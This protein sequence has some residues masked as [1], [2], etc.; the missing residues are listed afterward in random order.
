MSYSTATLLHSGFVTNCSSALRNGLL[1]GFIGALCA[2]S[3]LSD[4]ADA[5]ASQ[6][7]WK[8]VIVTGD[9]FR[10]V[11]YQSRQASIPR[12]T[13]H[14]YIEGD[15][16]PWEAGGFIASAD[17]TPARPLALELMAKDPSPSL[18][19]GRPCYF[20]LATDTACETKYWTSARYST[21]VIASM[22]TAL[23]HYARAQDAERLVLI[24]YSGGGVVATLMTQHLEFPV[25]VV[26]L[27][28]NLDIDTWAHN[29]RFLPLDQSINPMNSA[30]LDGVRHRHFAGALDA[31]V[32]PDII[33]RFSSKHNG[34]FVLL[35]GVDHSCCWVDK[36][37]G[38]LH[39]EQG[40]QPEQ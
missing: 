32:K 12:Q 2:C 23:N 16:R 39:H 31:N 10:H 21:P 14:V 15:G 26:T 27:G 4:Q 13:V 36:W 8:R 35:P 24:G 20:G 11:S 6:Q 34:E 25:S 40:T 22:A 3:S 1:A 29:H 9:T 18:Y 38:L 19:L 28:S 30:G 7:G 5:F 33:Q 37:P 17:P